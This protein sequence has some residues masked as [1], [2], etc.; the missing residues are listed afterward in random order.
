MERRGLTPGELRVIKAYVEYE[1]HE[2]AA[3]HLGISTQTL[4]NHLGSIYKKLDVK[5]AH[6]AVYQ[7]TL[8]RG[9]DIFDAV[10]DENTSTNSQI[11]G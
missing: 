6:S 10:P 5:K 7:L 8:M 9:L 3:S 2:A 11:S 4:K 1:N